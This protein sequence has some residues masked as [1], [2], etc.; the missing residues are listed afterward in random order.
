M[1]TNV[2]VRAWLAPD[3]A[4]NQARHNGQINRRIDRLTDMA[5]RGT[6]SVTGDW[7]VDERCIRC[8]V[9]RHWAPG[10]IEQDDRGRSYVVRQP[11][12]GEDEQALWRAAVACPTQS[13]HR[14]AMP[15]PSQPPFPHEMTPG[16]LALGHN[17]RKSFGAHSYL[18]T[19]PDGHVMFDTP[20]FERSLVE[21]VEALGGVAHILLSHRDDVADYD[22]WAG[23]F[24]SQVWIHEAEAHAAPNATDI[25][26]GGDSAEM[27][28][29]V[30][31]YVAPGHTEGHL[32][33]HVDNRWLF[34]GDTLLWN[35]RRG[36]LDVTPLQMFYSWEALTETVEML[37][38]LRVE[39]VLPGHGS[40]RQ[41]EPSD[42]SADMQRLAAGMRERG[43]R[44][45]ASRPNTPFDWY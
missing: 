17:S 44:G 29:G 43:R 21:R 42:Y 39:W 2:P 33:F 4:A 16:L 8:D 11:V 31:A 24:G 15:R 5:T 19:R 10:L 3:E 23:H 38:T 27:A 14:Q 9:A 13:V 7:S 25:V 18:A 28:P 20:R 30:V 26:R 32:V 37:A 6:A 36:E 35:Q 34:T 40:W 22:R 45:W 41:L 12:S 1:P